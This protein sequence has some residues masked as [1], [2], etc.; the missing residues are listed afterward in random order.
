MTLILVLG[1]NPTAIGSKE[2]S[3]LHVSK[4]VRQTESHF[5]KLCQKINTLSLQTCTFPFLLNVYIMFTLRFNSMSMHALICACVGPPTWNNCRGNLVKLLVVFLNLVS[6]NCRKAPIRSS[7]D[8]L[9][10]FQEVFF[11]GE[12]SWYITIRLF[13]KKNKNAIYDVNSFALNPFF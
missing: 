5:L 7:L 2:S 11:W 3:I 13:I 1:V 4:N 8:H 6:N 9:H 12:R 10:F